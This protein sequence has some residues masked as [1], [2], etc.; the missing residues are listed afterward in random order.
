MTVFTK[1]RLATA[2]AFA[3][4]F[5]AGLPLAWGFI[6][7]TSDGLGIF[8]LD[9]DATQESGGAVGPPFVAGADDWSN[10]L[11]SG[12]KSTVDPAIATLGTTTGGGTAAWPGVIPAPGGNTIAFGGG[13]KDILDLTSWQWNTGSA[14]GKNLITDAYAAAY[15]LNKDIPGTTTNMKGDLI[16]FFGLDRKANNGDA[17]LGFWFFQQTVTLKPNPPAGFNGTHTQG[18]ILV[19]MNFPQGSPSSPTVRILEWTT[20]PPGEISGTLHDLT[21]MLAGTGGVCDNTVD[22]VGCG[23]TN[24]GMV[25]APWPYTPKSG[26]AGTFPTESFFEGA[27]N[28]SRA[29]RVLGIPLP[30]LTSFLAETRSSTSPTASLQDFIVG[31][32]TVCNFDLTKNCTDGRVNDAQNGFTWT[33]SGTVHNTGAAPLHDV[34]VFDTPIG[35]TK[36]QVALLGDIAGGATVSYGPLTYDTI[37][38]SP[39]PASDTVEVTA[40]G[41]EGGPVILDKTKDATCKQVKI[42]PM[43]SLNKTCD[44]ASGN[45]GPDASTLGAFI[46]LVNNELVVEATVNVHLCNT[47][48]VNWIN[49]VVKDDDGNPSTPLASQETLVP[50]S[51]LPIVNGVPTLKAMTCADYTHTYT[52]NGSGITLPAKASTITLHDTATLF[53]ADE[54]LGL[55]SVPQQSSTAG[56]PLCQ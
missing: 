23:I 39:N 24:V 12:G 8:E 30:C 44:P 43:V 4:G 15:V 49:V 47:G 38:S 6:P 1:R 18:D 13:T 46:N 2:A 40:A 3:V 45:A 41:V 51:P 54:V 14:P 53:S 29:F 19:L 28:I 50:D 5:A 25:T 42:S 27:L 32:F 48:A 55:G 10:I 36:T 37:G 21:P 9:G 33:Y 16:L 52:P 11:I 31:S 26:T 17:D 7:S 22:Q 20:S 35:G 56:C 34:T